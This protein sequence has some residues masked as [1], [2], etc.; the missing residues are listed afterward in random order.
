MLETMK[1]ILEEGKRLNSPV[2]LSKFGKEQTGEYF[3]KSSKFAG[4]SA[5]IKSQGDVQGK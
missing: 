5:E 3:S 1:I 2:R 4:G